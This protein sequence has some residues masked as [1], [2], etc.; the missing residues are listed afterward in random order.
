LGLLN[1]HAAPECEL[2][3]L[4]VDEFTIASAAGRAAKWGRRTTFTQLDIGKEADRIPEA[5]VYLAF[6]IFPYL[7][8]PVSLLEILSAKLQ[9]GGVLIVRQYDGSLLR[10]GPINHLYRLTIERALH[11]ALVGSRQFRHFDL[12]RVFELLNGSPFSRKEF[13]FDLFSRVSPFPSEFVEYFSNTVNWTSKYVSTEARGIL[14]RWY[15]CYV[16]SAPGLPSYF[17]EVDLVAWLS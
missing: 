6:N 7:E 13:E 12:D 17:V 16:R 1:E 15:D 3:G 8:H 14:E 10:F 2:V 11:T 4:D 9:T 5:D